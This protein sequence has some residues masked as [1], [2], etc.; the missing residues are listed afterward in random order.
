[1]PKSDDKITIEN[2]TSPGHTY[3]VNRRKYEAMRDA[4]DRR[5]RLARNRH[6]WCCASGEDVDDHISVQEGC[7]HLRQPVDIE[8]WGYLGRG[9][10]RLQHQGQRQH[11]GRANL[12][13]ARPEILR[14]DAHQ[15]LPWRTLVLLRRRSP[16]RRMAQISC[17]GCWHF[18]S[19][20]CTGLVQAFDRVPKIEAAGGLNG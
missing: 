4:L 14:Q 18:L 13:R 12:P 2:F 5:T 19:L 8:R 15:R 20:C 11:E 3:R 7:T 1:M 17:V 6:L 9:A 16:S 10:W